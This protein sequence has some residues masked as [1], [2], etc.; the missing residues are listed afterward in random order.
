METAAVYWVI[1][2]YS[3]V[4]FAGSKLFCPHICFISL[5][6]DIAWLDAGIGLGHCLWAPYF[7][8]DSCWL[9]VEDSYV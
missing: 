2:V 4:V 9:C 6:S 1:L 7:L 8:T 5:P 3:L